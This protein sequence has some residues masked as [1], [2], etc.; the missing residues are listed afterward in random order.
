MLHTS[1]RKVSN[2]C[3]FHHI[4]LAHW[5][6]YYPV[7]S[8]SSCSDLLG[9]R[10][11][12]HA[13]GEDLRFPHHDNEIA[14]CEAFFGCQQWV[15]YFLH[16]GHL[17]IEGLKMS[18][19]LK[20]FITIREMLKYYSARAIRLLF[21]L[22]SW[23]A[24]MNFSRNGLREAAV[25]EK[26]LKEFFLNVKTVLRS[27][28]ASVDA[29]QRWSDADRTLHASLLRAQGVVHAALLDNFDY[30]TA[31]MTLFDLVNETNKYLTAGAAC[32]ALLLGKV[33]AY[34]FKM[35]RVFGVLDQEPL[36]FAV[37]GANGGGGAQSAEE[38]L[39]PVLDAFTDFRAQIRQSA[40]DRVPHDELLAQ[41]DAVRDNV[42]PELGV[43][44]E[45]KGQAGSVWKLDDP[46]VLIRE[47]DE[48]RAAARAN[49]VKKLTSQL[50]AREADLEKAIGAATPALEFIAAQRDKYSA[51]DAAG[52]PTHDH[53]GKEL[54][55]KNRQFA[56]KQ[57]AKQ[58]ELNAWLQKTIEKEGA[59]FV[60]Q[61]RAEIARLGAEIAA[62]SAQ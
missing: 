50:K 36:G 19:S 7:T 38:S 45:D 16:A 41:C 29:V 12:V 59:D 62:A 60:D 6:C 31:M 46:A 56:E 27:A 15:N 33:A 14:Q 17:H 20:N 22:Q 42:L 53:E 43:R 39:A 51:F 1:R 3:F 18:K 26:Q 48:K 37:Q 9:T 54:S 47:R 13:G 10:L 35:L 25:K 11:D 21:L 40:R 28:S 61:L 24:R 58:V 52:L 2:Y 8:V 55:K 32:K 49:A 44:L 34:V 4:F 5:Y 57:M 23:H 30:P